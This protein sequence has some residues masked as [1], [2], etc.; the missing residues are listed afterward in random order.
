MNLL[1]DPVVLVPCSHTFCKGCMKGMD[2]C[3]ECNKKCQGF[4]PSTLINDIV[5]KYE[6]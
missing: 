3:A 2:K 1:K 5:A 6:F 4:V